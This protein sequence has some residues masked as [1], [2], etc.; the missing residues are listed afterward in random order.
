MCLEIFAQVERKIS[1]CG[2]REQRRIENHDCKEHRTEEIRRH[3]RGTLPVVAAVV[4]GQMI[5]QDS[6]AEVVREILR[7]HHHSKCGAGQGKQ[8]LLAA[9]IASWTL[10][11]AMVKIEAGEHEEDEQRVFLDDP[12]DPD[13]VET[14]RPQQC[15]HQADSKSKQSSDEEEER[16]NRERSEDRVRQ[17]Q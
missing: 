16:N 9:Y 14:R 8:S 15:R 3:S 13:S 6:Q 1:P 4:A 5:K 11:G 10:L 2:R 12:V 17:T 7:C